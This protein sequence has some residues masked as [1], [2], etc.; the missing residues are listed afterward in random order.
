MPYKDKN[1]QNRYQRMNY[2]H[3][4]Y[5]KRTR[6]KAIIC[7]GGKCVGCGIDN[8]DVLQFD[9]INNDGYIER[10]Y[11]NGIRNVNDAGIG[12]QLYAKIIKYDEIAMKYQLLCANCN[13]LKHKLY[14]ELLVLQKRNIP[15]F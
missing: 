11:T 15:P 12:R 2:D 4:I 8:F 5:Y 7:L 13:M 1:I 14:L 10:K 9:H 6:D 3:R